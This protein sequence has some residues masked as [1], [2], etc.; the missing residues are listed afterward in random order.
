MDYYEMWPDSVVCQI[1]METCENTH[2][3]SGSINKP[4]L[5]EGW[6]MVTVYVLRAGE[7]ASLGLRRVTWLRRV[8]EHAHIIHTCFWMMSLW[9]AALRACSLLASAACLFFCCC[10]SLSCWILCSCSWTEAAWMV[11]TFPICADNVVRWGITF[12]NA[13]V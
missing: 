5:M 10:C 2:I 7:T 8:H 6:R 13:L 1:D 9:L 4:S 12:F 11:T 3:S